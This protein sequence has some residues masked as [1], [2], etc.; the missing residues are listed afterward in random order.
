MGFSRKE[1]WGGL[2]FFL[3]QG[4]IPTQGLN[5]HLLNWRVDSLPLSHLGSARRSGNGAASDKVWGMTRSMVAK[6]QILGSTEVKSLGV[7]WVV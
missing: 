1:Y 4:I 6:E 3:L 7:R 5:P 2:P